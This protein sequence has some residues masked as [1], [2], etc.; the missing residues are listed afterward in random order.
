MD[1][2]RQKKGQLKFKT[3]KTYKT[4]KTFKT[5]LYYAVFESIK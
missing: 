1:I 3:Y 4:F 5:K 2:P